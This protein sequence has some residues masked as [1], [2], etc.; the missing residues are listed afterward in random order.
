ML[1]A[2]I[3]D[4]C[5]LALTAVSSLLKKYSINPDSIGR[6]EVGT[7]SPYDKAKSVKSV[8]TQLFGDNH[9]MEGVDTVHACYGGTNAL[10]NAI[11]WVES[12]SWDGRD[13]IVVAS[14]I[15]IYK[16]PS[17]RPTGGAGCVA[18]LVGPNAPIV[19]IP[20]LRGTYMTNTYDFYKPEMHSE[21]PTLDG[22]LSISCY[23]SALDGCYADLQK[24][25]AR[26]LANAER[27]PEA[28]ALLSRDRQTFVDVFDHMAFH[29]PNC[30]LVSKSYGRLLYHDFLYDKTSHPAFA[31]VPK[32]LHNLSY[33]ESQQSKEL[34][35]A[36]VQLSKPQFKQRIESCIEAPSRCG[37][38]YTAS[39]YCSL[40]SVLEAVGSDALQGKTIGLFSYGSG[41]A[42]SLF[43]MQVVGDVSE[44][45][46][47]VDLFARLDR[48]HVA[49][50]EEYEE[51]CRMR[52]DAY[53]KKGFTP[54]GGLEWIGE[55][56]YYIDRVDEE[57]RRAYKVKGAE[58]NGVEDKGVNGVH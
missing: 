34:E 27:Y 46:E 57:Y 6:L 1:T 53:G 24:C 23:L 49:K 12:R 33:K 25:A 4:V 41:L 58:V 5:S 40:L 52:E 16:Q 11:N 38:M 29:T 50:P 13:A 56:V 3:P 48:R 2:T 9:S 20:G 15:A 19:S 37:N 28:H 18:I 39:L 30:K 44:M 17:A 47:K 54:R 7:E 26:A 51:A 43:T 42:S 32:H 21:Y 22:K 10:F 45:V 36:F 35:T 8:L 14:D 31:S 55:G